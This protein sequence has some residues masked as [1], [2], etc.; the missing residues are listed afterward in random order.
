MI[1]RPN[2]VTQDPE[3]FITELGNRLRAIAIESGVGRSAEPRRLFEAKE[4]RAAV[5][6]AMTL[7]E[8][9]LRERLNKSS[10]PNVRRPLSLRSLI[11]LAV[12]QQIIPSEFKQRADSWMRLRNEVVHSSMPISKTEAREIVEGVFAILRTD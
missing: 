4:Y 9:T 10:W 1:T 3:D 8:A 2:I 6:S 7:L 11:D 5:I 12:E